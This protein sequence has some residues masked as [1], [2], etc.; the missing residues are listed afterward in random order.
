[1]GKILFLADIHGNM[2][3]VEAL[4][5]E[6]DIILGKGK[7]KKTANL[8]SQELMAFISD[9]QRKLGT[10]VTLLGNDKKGRIYI[11]YYSQDD[12]E[13]IYDIILK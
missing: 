8:P 10:K 13:R 11:D 1:M 3:A 9:L 5:K 12:L 4:E 7:N 6:I 2:P